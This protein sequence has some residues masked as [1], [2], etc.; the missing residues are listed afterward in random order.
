[1][2]M[3]MGPHLWACFLCSCAFP[4]FILVTFQI[5]AKAIICP[6][7]QC[8]WSL[9]TA[10]LLW[11]WEKLI[12]LEINKCFTSVETWK[13]SKHTLLK[14]QMFP[15]VRRFHRSSLIITS[16]LGHLWHPNYVTLLRI[17]S[18]SH[19]YGF[20]SKRLLIPRFRIGLLWVSL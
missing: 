12:P 13:C 6:D 3:T 17:L 1:M 11:F 4:W 5:R 18:G 19:V 8:G 16:K 10:C 20:K 2:R 14:F 15:Q 9:R 7:K